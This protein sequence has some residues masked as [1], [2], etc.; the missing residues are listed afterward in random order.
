MNEVF[1]Y[2]NNS[3]SF[4]IA[5][6]HSALS[7]KEKTETLSKFREGKIKVVIATIALGMG[8]DF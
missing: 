1:N 6:Y 4:N 5:I 7:N 3:T 8:L 2:V